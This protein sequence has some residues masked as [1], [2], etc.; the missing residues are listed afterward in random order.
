MVLW[1][2]FCAVVLEAGWRFQVDS[3]VDRD[4]G[5]ASTNSS[6]STTASTSTSSCIG[7]CITSVPGCDVRGP[8]T[9]TGIVTI[10]DDAGKLVPIP[11]PYYISI[12]S[13]I[14][15]S[16]ANSTTGSSS[17]ASPTTSSPTITATPSSTSSCALG[18]GNCVT[19]VPGCD[20]RGPPTQTGFVTITDDA[21]KLVPVPCYAY[22]SL[23]SQ[24]VS[25]QA[26][27]ALPNATITS[28]PSSTSSCVGNCI[29]SVPG[30]DVRGPTT[31]TGFVT[32][33][34]DAGKLVPV[35]CYIYISLWNQAQ[36]PQTSTAFPN[37]TITSPPSST[38][39][40]VGNCITSVPGCDVRGPTTQTGIVTITDVNGN[41]V[42]VPCPFYI[43]IWNSIESSKMNMTTTP[44]SD[45]YSTTTSPNYP[46]F[47][48]GN[49]DTTTIGSCDLFG[50]LCQTGTIK[51]LVNRNGTTSTTSVACSDYLSAQKYA[52][53]SSHQNEGIGYPGAFAASFGRSPQ[54]SSFSKLSLQS[55]ALN[56]ATQ[57]YDT[58]IVSTWGASY[59]ASIQSQDYSLAGYTL[60]GTSW[61]APK[62]TPLPGCPSNASAFDTSLYPGAIHHYAGAGH[63]WDCCGFCVLRVPQ[64]QVFYWPD[65]S[66]N[67]SSGLNT[68]NATRTNPDPKAPHARKRAPSL[69]ERGF[70]TAIVD[71]YT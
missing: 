36:S 66:I 32:I 63:E 20:V 31:Q 71:G 58:T 6:T 24:L 17:I 40:C 28:P 49:Y 35:P 61:I 59:Y 50:A 42:P 68:T 14:E 34:D 44:S 22:I 51:A 47:V 8:L 46:N 54:C 45:S 52:Y 21:G 39:S 60:S 30:C 70:A 38:S 1:V 18:V 48:Y 11:C 69:V 16:K 10:T 67:G 43:S 55:L 25:S 9:Q 12:W 37:A 56:G 41:L 7:N 27:T 3:Y 29:T 57:S 13:S 23:W 33:T 2:S 5:N 65:Q 15:A 53:Q 62:A 64:L 19:S 26:N 4:S